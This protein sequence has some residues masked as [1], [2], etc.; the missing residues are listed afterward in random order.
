MSRHDEGSCGEAIL[1]ASGYHGGSCGEAILV[2]SGYHE[3]R[4][5]WRRGIWRVCVVVM[6]GGQRTHTRGGEE[7]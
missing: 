2:A 4:M 1:V 6:V 5:L 7:V 3:G